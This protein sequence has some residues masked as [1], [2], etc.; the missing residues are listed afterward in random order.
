PL[1]AKQDLTH[2]RATPHF[3]ASA[4]TLWERHYELIAENM[5]RFLAGRPLLNQVGKGRAHRL[6]DFR[7]LLESKFIETYYT[8]KE[9]EKIVDVLL[10][11]E[12]TGKNTQGVLKLLSSEPI[13]NIKPEYPP[14]VIKETKV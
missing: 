12:M 8:K 5:A 10:Y 11:G 7:T 1:P 3:T 2:R 14:K 4:A 13:Q 6:G 9:A